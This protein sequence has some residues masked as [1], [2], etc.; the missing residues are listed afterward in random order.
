MKTYAYI[1]YINRELLANK[2]KETTRWRDM[3]KLGVPRTQANVKYTKCISPVRIV[4]FE[5]AKRAATCYQLEYATREKIYSRHKRHGLA[6]WT[7]VYYCQTR[8]IRSIYIP[9]V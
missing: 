4:K 5:R 9:R 7:C 8:E 6:R 3:G 2:K 1:V